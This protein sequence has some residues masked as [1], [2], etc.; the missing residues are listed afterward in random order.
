MLLLGGV[1]IAG[2]IILM[3]VFQRSMRED[4]AD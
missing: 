4:T 2:A 1:G 3:F